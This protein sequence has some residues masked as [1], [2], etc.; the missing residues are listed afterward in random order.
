MQGGTRMLCPGTWLARLGVQDSLKTSFLEMRQLSDHNQAA[1]P[2]G[3]GIFFP[4]RG[5]VIVKH[6]ECDPRHPVRF[7][8]SFSAQTMPTHA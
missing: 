1:P 8:L 2:T 3:W 5:Q 6:L 4:L 7:I